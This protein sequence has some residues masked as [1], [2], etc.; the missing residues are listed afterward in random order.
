MTFER[1]SLG[2]RAYALVSTSLEREGFLAAFTERTGGRGVGPYRA[3]NVSFAVGDDPAV[4]ASNR[5]AIADGLGIPPFAVAGLVHGSRILRV[6]PRRAGAG[7]ARAEEVVAGT[8]GLMTGTVGL[9]IAVTTADCVP[10]VLAS[11][12]E[13]TV[14]VVHV[15]WKGLAAGIVSASARRFAEPKAVRA[16][17]GPAIG[18][19]HYEVGD[20]VALAVSAA[21]PVGA[22]L[23][24]RN[25]RL[26][27]D[28][29]ETV[30][31]IL[32][33]HGIREVEDTGLCT[34]CEARRFFSHRR[35]GVSGRQIA[36]ATR[37]E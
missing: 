24:R 21:S 27:L 22:A 4:V 17:I 19:C 14:A 30:R 20:D 8:D 1:R 2:G 26:H 9:P 18:P 7:F 16:A 25:R 12:R 15:G 33:E 32:R 23:E 34:A 28:L 31:W 37:L 36:I 13:G 35:D 29:V 5:V 10:L 6:G 11:G 3:L